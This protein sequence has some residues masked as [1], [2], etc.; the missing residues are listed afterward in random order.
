M[1]VQIILGSDRPNRIGG[2][3][4][5]WVVSSAA[6]QPDFEVELVDL[7][8]YDLPHFDEAMSPRFNPNRQL[9]EAAERWL[10]K[11]NEADAYVIVTP[12]YNHSITGILKDALDYLDW[13]FAK[14][15][16]A[17][18]SYGTVGGARAAEQ[19]KAILIEVK[20]AIVPEA[21]ALLN[22]GQ[23]VSDGGVL[24][25]ELKAAPYG[26]Q[27]ALDGTLAELHW[28]A[29]TL[30]AGREAALTVA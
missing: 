17:I 19:L 9:N 5:K 20:A 23:A 24:S 26:P 7:K 6:E 30:K 1:K 2:K 13:Q 8:D 25:D 27:T 28:W 18:V 15:P 21:V 14:K 16:V 4:A 3:I 22:P 11:V 29:K 12:E 10:A